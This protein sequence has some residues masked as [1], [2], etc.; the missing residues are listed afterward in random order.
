[1]YRID[2]STAALAMPVIGAIGPNVDGFFTDG[3]PST[4]T[5]ST[6]VPAD[7]LNSF[8]EELCR[9][10]ESAGVDLVKGDYEQLRLAID[11]LAQKNEA[12]YGT[13]T[14]SPNTYTVTLDPAPEQ[15]TEGMGMLIKFTNA[16]TASVATINANTL[17]AKNIKRYDGTPLA[18]GDIADDCIALLIYDGTNFLMM[19]T[20]TALYNN[21]AHS[22]SVANTY[23]VT[24]S[25]TAGAYTEG[26]FLLIKFDNHNTGAATLNVDG[27]GAKDIKRNDG[28]AL[29]AYDIYDGMIGHLVYDGTNFQLMNRYGVKQP[30]RTIYTSGSGTYTTPIGASYIK[31]KCIGAGGGGGGSWKSSPPAVAGAG[32]DTTFGSLSAGG[33]G[34]GVFGG[35][36]GVGG[37]A[38]GGDINFSGA[39]GGASSGS[40]FTPGSFSLMLIGGAG[41]GVPMHSP[42]TPHLLGG[43]EVGTNAQNNTGSGGSGGGTNVYVNPGN[44]GGGGGGGAYVD[45]QINNPSSTYSYSVGA[46]GVAG[47]AG[48][49]GWAGGTGGSGMIII[50]AYFQ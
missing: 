44:S 33:G 5:P 43:I 49:S 3:D 30:Q 27:L 39:N 42:G 35:H 11:Y 19:N 17:G 21:Y 40:N 28:S 31:V 9:F 34:G 2:N 32:G 1:M 15:Y 26:M 8:Q 4:A 47:V 41:G 7:W 6:I 25:T 50:E 16:N 36:G 48:D 45:K 38:S 10:V 12:T 46:G 23:A 13:S 18:V 22:V 20:A 24:L 37:T 29:R 14:S